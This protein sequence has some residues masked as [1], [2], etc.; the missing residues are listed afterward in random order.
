MK[1][2]L[3]DKNRLLHILD[4]IKSIEEFTNNITYW[5]YIDDYKLRLALVK[6]LE[7]IG[8]ASNGITRETQEKFS[9]VEWAVLRGIRNTLVHEYFGIDYDIVWESIKQNIPNLKGKIETILKEL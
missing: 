4:S 5:D 6:L 8:E 1:N 3:T 2:K 7:I 9:E